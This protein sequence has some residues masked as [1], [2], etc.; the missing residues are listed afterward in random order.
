MPVAGERTHVT[1]PN[2]LLIMVRLRSKPCRDQT[3]E[4]RRDG[5]PGA[6]LPAGE[7][8]GKDQ[9]S[10]YCLFLPFLDIELIWQYSFEFS[11]KN[12][13]N[14]IRKTIITKNAEQAEKATL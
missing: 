6:R 8:G 10:F 5:K 13:I 4:E 3:R 12:H 2:V 9:V 14:A 7:C 1:Q 11:Q